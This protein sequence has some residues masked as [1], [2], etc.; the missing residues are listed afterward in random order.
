MTEKIRQARA[1]LAKKER[2]DV[3]KRGDDNINKIVWIGVVILVIGL[4][5]GL[6]IFLVNLLGDDAA[7]EA[8][9][10]TTQDAAVYDANCEGVSIG[11]I[12]SLGSTG[13]ATSGFQNA[14][15]DVLLTYTANTGYQHPTVG[16][17]NAPT[18]TENGIEGGNHAAI[19]DLAFIHTVSNVT[20]S[21]FN[22]DFNSDGRITDGQVAALIT[23]DATTVVTA[24]PTGNQI[25]LHTAEGNPPLLVAVG[26]ADINNVRVGSNLVLDRR[27]GCW[28]V[29]V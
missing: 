23:D 13:D 19:E 12:G 5:A 10:I 24:A 17:A 27:A 22:A 1:W 25:R 9:D 28:G 21:R 4:V 16:H 3:E 18:A 15:T 14:Q 6:L 26:N 8:Q 29:K 20:E 7:E 11:R 2:I